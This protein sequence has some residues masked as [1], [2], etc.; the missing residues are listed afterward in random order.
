MRKQWPRPSGRVNDDKPPTISRLWRCIALWRLGTGAS[1]SGPAG[2]SSP[3]CRLSRLCVPKPA[4][5]FSTTRLLGAP[6]RS[7]RAHLSQPRMTNSGLVFHAS[8]SQLGIAPDPCNNSLISPNLC[9]SDPH[10]QTTCLVSVTLEYSVHRVELVHTSTLTR[11]GEARGG[12]GLTRPRYPPP[13]PRDQ[14]S[15]LRMTWAVKK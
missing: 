6:S 12:V 4:T 14:E 2:L 15:G 11:G 7:S 3:S 9:T 10:G 1:Q 8:H 5:V 13:P